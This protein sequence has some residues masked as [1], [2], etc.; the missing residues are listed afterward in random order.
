MR[1]ENVLVV[2]LIC[3]VV[4]VGVLY[5]YTGSGK[6]GSSRLNTG[7]ENTADRTGIAWEN[8]T[9][10]LARAKAEGKPV[11]LY[12]HADWCTFCV[13]LKKTTFKDKHVL[14]LLAKDFVSI[15]I[16]TD[17]QRDLAVKWRVTGLPTMWFLKPDGS[18]IDRIPGF[19]NAKNMVKILN[20]L[21]TKQY[22]QVSFHDFLKTL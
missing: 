22:Q 12:F 16:D 2:V 20:F 5:K 8:M 10:G 3:L 7:Q 4:A 9:E 18:E 21:S 11:F 15:S 6:P 1:K 17:K 14:K 13:K 19:V